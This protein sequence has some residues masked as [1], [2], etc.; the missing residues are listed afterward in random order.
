MKK[1][2]A[3]IFLF[4]IL[5]AYVGGFANNVIRHI[6]YESQF[7]LIING[8]EIETQRPIVLIDG[9]TYIPIKELETDLNL[10]VAWEPGR[11]RVHINFDEDDTMRW[12]GNEQSFIPENGFIPNEYVAIKV[13]EPIL[14][15]IYGEESINRQKPFS[16]EKDPFFNAWI[17]R[18]SLPEGYRGGVFTIVIRRNDG[19]LLHVSQDR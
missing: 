13:A 19:R 6:A 11:E 4:L 3:I 7:P 18:G 15:A 2:L 9:N 16:V 14:I 5:I 12:W 17:I 8:R 1:S 10:I